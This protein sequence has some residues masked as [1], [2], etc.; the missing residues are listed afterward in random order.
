MLNRK[1]KTEK[2]NN[3]FV[4]CFCSLLVPNNVNFL[5]YEVNFLRMKLYLINGITRS[6]ELK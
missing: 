3:P 4:F 6:V 1:P 5:C 2:Y